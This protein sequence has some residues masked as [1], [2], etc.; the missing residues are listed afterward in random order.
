MLAEGLESQGYSVGIWSWNPLLEEAESP[1]T[2]D[3]PKVVEQ[4]RWGGKCSLETSPAGQLCSI[5]GLFCVVF[6]AWRCGCVASQVSPEDQLS[7]MALLQDSRAPSGKEWE[8]VRLGQGG[9]AAHVWE[10]PQSAAPTFA[11][12]HSQAS[13]TASLAI[14]GTNPRVRCDFPGEHQ[15]GRILWAWSYQL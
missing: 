11:P 3:F 6:Q 10:R 1:N 7:G 8:G 2:G 9:K 5:L 13:Q 14:T 4:A 15:G 12:D